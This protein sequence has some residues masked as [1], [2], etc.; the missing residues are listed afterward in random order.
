MN[1]MLNSAEVDVLFR[2]DPAAAGKGG[3][4]DFLIRL[5][6]KCD[7]T[8]GEILLSEDDVK[9]IAK[10]AFDYKG[11]GWQ[12]RLLS[13]FERSLGPNLGRE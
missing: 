7:R 12:G 3:F 6:R 1:I 10:Y 5:Q 11:G 4:Q 2:Q 9:L 13:I 8:T